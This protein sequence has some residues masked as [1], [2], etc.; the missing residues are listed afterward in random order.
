MKNTFSYGKVPQASSVDVVALE[1]T[2]SDNS[3]VAAVDAGDEAA[4]AAADADAFAEEDKVQPPGGSEPLPELPSLPVRF[5]CFRVRKG[6]S[7]VL[8]CSLRKNHCLK[9]HLLPRKR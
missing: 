6:D 5:F 7:N 9:F 1:A 8:L 3:V 4:A 2:K